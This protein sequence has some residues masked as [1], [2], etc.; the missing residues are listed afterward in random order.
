M[1]YSRGTLVLWQVVMPFSPQNILHRR[2]CTDRA[3]STVIESLSLS[4]VNE[5]HPSSYSDFLGD[6]NKRNS[7]AYK[8]TLTSTD[9]CSHHL[10]MGANDYFHDSLYPTSSDSAQQYPDPY[11]KCAN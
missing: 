11:Q 10:G 1:K 7:Q 9:E 4:I 2:K 5:G 3:G 6:T 8:G